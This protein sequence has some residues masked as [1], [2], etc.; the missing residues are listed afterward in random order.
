MKFQRSLV[1]T[2]ILALSHTF[3]YADEEVEKYHEAVVNSCKRRENITMVLGAGDYPENYSRF[4]A[5]QKSPKDYT[6]LV[7]D[8]KTASLAAFNAYNKSLNT[9]H[10]D[11]KNLS[12]IKLSGTRVDNPIPLILNFNE[13]E[14]TVFLDKVKG[15]FSKIIFDYSVTKF[16]SDKDIAWF[17]AIYNALNDNGVFI[18]NQ[19][20]TTIS[21]IFVGLPKYRGNKLDS[22]QYQYNEMTA[23]GVLEKIY[24]SDIFVSKISSLSLYHAGKKI[25]SLPGP[26]DQYAK[27]ESL[28]TK[29]ELQEL[30]VHDP[31]FSDEEKF[32]LFNSRAQEAYDGIINRNQVIIK[33]AGFKLVEVHKNEPYPILFHKNKAEITTFYI[34]HKIDP[35]K[36]DPIA[37]LIKSLVALKKSLEALALKL[38]TFS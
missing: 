31:F 21:T 30:F 23:P 16:L 37:K 33:K 28:D 36:K 9:A 1:L 25:L 29:K 12:E 5:S 27:I 17:E 18:M 4:L 2:C 38:K 15:K 11:I 8:R 20:F 7:N 13:P 26:H 32:S 34:A 22:L 19:S 6:F 35:A 3:M 14:F 24:S 10:E